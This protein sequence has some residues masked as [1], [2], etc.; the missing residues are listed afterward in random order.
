MSP[1]HLSKWTFLLDYSKHF[2]TSDNYFRLKD[3]IAYFQKLR[4]KHRFKIRKIEKAY[5]K[6]LKKKRPTIRE[7]HDMNRYR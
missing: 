1:D 4:E 3:Q 5:M 7:I 6:Y 2:G